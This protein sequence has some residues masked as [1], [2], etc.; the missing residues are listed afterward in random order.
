[1]VKW[2]KVVLIIKK[3]DM[4]NEVPDREDYISA[5]YA[6]MNQFELDPFDF[7]VVALKSRN[8]EFKKTWHV[9]LK[10]RKRREDEYWRTYED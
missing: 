6:Y 3:E 8:K 4:F 5:W 10:F 9:T 7:Q 1:M 2:K